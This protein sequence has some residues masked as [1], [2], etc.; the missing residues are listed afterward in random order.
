MQ[1]DKCVDEHDGGEE[2]DGG[3]EDAMFTDVPSAPAFAQ[4]MP[5]DLQTDEDDVIPPSFNIYTDVSQSSSDYL[6]F[7]KLSDLPR[8]LQEE[9]TARGPDSKQLFC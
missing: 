3:K 4:T 7:E 8:L 6:P 2:N 1:D 9:M 5:Y